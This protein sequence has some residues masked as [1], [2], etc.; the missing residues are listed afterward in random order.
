MT[1]IT[2]RLC[3][4]YRAKDN[5]YKVYTKYSVDCNK[6]KLLY[7]DRQQLLQYPIDID[8][9]SSLKA[10]AKLLPPLVKVDKFFRM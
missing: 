4:V 8:T 2:Y 7:P 1:Y 5:K 3:V 6:E 9:Q 10:K